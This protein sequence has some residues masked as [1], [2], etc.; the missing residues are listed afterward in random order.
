MKTQHLEVARPP[1]ALAAVLSPGVPP[2]DLYSVDGSRL[3]EKLAE[4]DVCE[5]T[6]LLRRVSSLTGE[7]LELACGGGRLALPLLSLGRPVT[8]IDLSP[9]MIHILENRYASLPA[10]RRRVPLMPLVAD[11]RN[12][13][14][15]RTFG[16]IVLGTTSIFLLD[17]LGRQELYRS[18]KRHLA[19]GGRFFVSVHESVLAPGSTATRIVPLRDES[20]SVALVSDQVRVDGRTRDVSILHLTRSVA[21]ELETRE[22]TSVVNMIPL[23]ELDGEL[24]EKGFTRVETIVASE[25]TAD[26]GALLLCGY[27]V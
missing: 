6:A 15:D 10:S 13:A 22:F 16:A 18:V 21:G 9:E 20:G 5:Q 14:L 25:A 26:V 3:Y 23:E 19:P 24:A 11:M 7:I 12:F 17:R 8:G 27:A 1:A 2:E 4:F